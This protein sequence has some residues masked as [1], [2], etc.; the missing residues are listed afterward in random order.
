[1]DPWEKKPSLSGQEQNNNTW[2]KAIETKAENQPQK[3]L[4]RSFL[5]MAVEFV[6]AARLSI[7]PDDN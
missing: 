4:Q 5:V 3:S 7:L 6:L 1:M 2:E